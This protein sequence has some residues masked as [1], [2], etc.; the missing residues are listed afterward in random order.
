ML[1]A[2]AQRYSTLPSKLLCDADSFDIMVF[3]VATTWEK[4]QMDKRKGNVDQNMYDQN[5]LQ[6][7]MKQ[8]KEK[9]ANNKS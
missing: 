7:M 2:L 6:T 1:D 9:Y 3:D 4:M 5:E 8:A